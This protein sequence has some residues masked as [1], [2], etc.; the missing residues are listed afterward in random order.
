MNCRSLEIR[1]AVAGVAAF[2][3]DHLKTC[4]RQL[5]GKDGAGKS[6]PD[7]NDIDFFECLRHGLISSPHRVHGMRGC[8]VADAQW[9]ALELDAVLVDQVEVIRVGPW[10]SNH[11]PGNFVFVSSVN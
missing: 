11:L 7:D 4:C 3:A 5:F 1:N 9:F 10:K 8:T 6:D 2:K